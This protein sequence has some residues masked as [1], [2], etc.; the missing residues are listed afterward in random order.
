M[1]PLEENIIKSAQQ[2]LNELHFALTSEQALTHFKEQAKELNGSWEDIAQMVKSQRLNEI[3]TLVGL[4]KTN[5]SGM[6]EDAIKALDDIEH[7][8][9]KLVRMNQW[10]PG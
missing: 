9:N 1:T 3:T 4:G 6:C 5:N 10:L 8:S 7:N 2:A